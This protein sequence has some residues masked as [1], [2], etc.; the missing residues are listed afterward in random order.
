MRPLPGQMDLFT[1]C[2]QATA[3]PPAAECRWAYLK[4]NAYGRGSAV[5]RREIAAHLSVDVREVSDLIKTLIEQQGKLIGTDSAG[6]W[7]PAD[8]AEAERATANIRSRLV[9][10]AVRLKM[11]NRWTDEEFTDQISV[12]IEKESHRE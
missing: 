12:I 10:L 3:A 4:T 8:E 11:L 7:I 1:D 2:A 9:S 6:V 5:S